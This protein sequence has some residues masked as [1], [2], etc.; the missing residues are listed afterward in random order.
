[1][2][3][4]K[5]GLYT[6]SSLHPSPSFSLILPSSSPFPSLSCSHFCLLSRVWLLKLSA[7]AS[8]FR[9][10]LLIH[11]NILHLL[12]NVSSTTSQLSNTSYAVSIHFIG[13]A[14]P[15][16]STLNTHSWGGRKRPVL[17]PQSHS[18]PGNTQ[19]PLSSPRVL[20][21]GPKSC[22]LNRVHL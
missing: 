19:T 17:L 4:N 16:P 2:C 12:I 1:M 22:P 21:T 7:P 11:S 18:Q 10:I 5:Y 20:T 15:A 3:Q 9:S 13:M 8:C 14:K 6:F